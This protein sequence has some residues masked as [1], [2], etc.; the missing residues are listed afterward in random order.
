MN[1]HTMRYK[2]WLSGSPA[3]ARISG[4][5]HCNRAC[6]AY[7]PVTVSITS[8]VTAGLSLLSLTYFTISAFVFG[9]FILPSKT[10]FTMSLA[11][12]VL[13]AWCS[14]ARWWLSPSRSS[15]VLPQTLQTNLVVRPPLATGASSTSATS[16][17]NGVRIC[18][19]VYVSMSHKKEIEESLDTEKAK[20]LE[21]DETPKPTRRV[22]RP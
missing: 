6:L 8:R 14:P 22:S 3:R 12:A 17:F 4:P 10:P 9:K 5:L 1:W 16:C 13:F 11:V 7:T 20:E 21:L 18:V 15:K 2:K 19:L